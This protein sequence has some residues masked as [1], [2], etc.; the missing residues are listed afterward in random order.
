MI[1]ETEKEI[2]QRETEILHSLIKFEMK[3]KDTQFDSD[4]VILYK[5][6]CKEY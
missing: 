2:G 5:N 1:S 4:Q 3:I 6:Y